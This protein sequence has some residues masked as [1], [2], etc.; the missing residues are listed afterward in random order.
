MRIYYS[1][2]ARVEMFNKVL[3]NPINVKVV[4]VRTWHPSTYLFNRFIRYTVGV[5]IYL[6]NNAPHLLTDFSKQFM[7]YVLMMFVDREPEILGKITAA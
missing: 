7:R 5:V 4:L 6:F 3:A 2:D 1:F